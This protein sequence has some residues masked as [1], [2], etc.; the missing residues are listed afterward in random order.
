VRREVL[1]DSFLD[2]SPDGGV[3]AARAAERR[4]DLE[5]FDS[6]LET[7]DLDQRAVFVLFEL[8]NMTGDQIAEALAIPLGTVYSRLRLARGGFRRAVLRATAR[9]T[10][11]FRVAGLS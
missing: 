5:L 7:L 2:E 8:E 1:D 9:R 10:G 6:A 11:G 4:E 3:D